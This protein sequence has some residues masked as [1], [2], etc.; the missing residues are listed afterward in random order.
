MSKS[1]IEW[2]QHTWNPVRG[3]TKVSPG[4]AHCYAETFAERFRGVPGQAYERGF[5]LR[6]APDMLEVPLKRK[7]PTK[8]FVNSMSDLFHKDVPFEY[9]DRVFAVMAEANQHTYQILTKRA[10]VMRAYLTTPGRQRM[11]GQFVDDGPRF[12]PLPNVW[13]G[14]S[15]ENQ[16]FADERIPLLLQTPAAVRF[17]SA[18]PLLESIDLAHFEKGTCWVC[19]GAGGD[20]CD[21]A[22]G[23]N[24]DNPGLDWVI[25]GGESGRGAR[26][27]DYRWA[28][29]L[30]E[31]CR[32]A[33][34]A[35]FVK[36]MG[37]R[38]QLTLHDESIRQL[39]L[40]DRKGGDPAEW[41][42]V[43]RVREFPRKD[44]TQ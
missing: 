2:T 11:V 28:Q 6:L 9:I 14:V 5:D 38:P 4:C 17:V 25:V 43:L 31:Q 40:C 15:V 27:F 36:Q 32:N 13:I 41:P 18:E 1:T 19:R 44:V 29:S 30:V 37:S 42:E 24:D 7:T 16:H 10:D 39:T 21:C 12:W 35:C 23:W 20:Q 8:Y 34:L 26:P 33:G 3:C 22:G